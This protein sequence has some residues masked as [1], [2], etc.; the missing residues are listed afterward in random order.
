MNAKKSRK[1]L[2]DALAAEFVF[3]AAQATVLPAEP[4]QAPEPESTLEP[5]VEV[6]T[7]LPEPQPAQKAIKPAPAKS[8]LM[9][10]LMD[11]PDK[12]A[13]IRLTVDLPESMHRKLSLLSARSGRKK[14]VIVRMLLEEALD[15]VDE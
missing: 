4:G 8:N 5:Q 2:D 3:G 14:A 10:K 6:E 9:S 11:T 1:S 13:T 12:E 15:G 7:P